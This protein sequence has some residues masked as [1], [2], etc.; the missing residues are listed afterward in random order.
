MQS[1]FWTWPWWFHIPKIALAL[2]RHSRLTQK[3]EIL[4]DWCHKYSLH[5]EEVWI[6]KGDHWP[7]FVFAALFLFVLAG[8]QE[9][10]DLTKVTGSW[11]IEVAAGE[12]YYY[13][14]MSLKEEAGSLSGTISESTGMLSNVPLADIQFDGTNLTFSFNSPT[15]PDGLERLVKAEFKLVESSLDGL[16]IV[17]S[18]D[19]SAPAKATRESE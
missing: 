16:V 15:P 2:S 4:L 19:V 11:K 17:P 1:S 3:L 18:I 9:K 13:L 8:A 7:V 6:M 10:P 12:A 14:T 5:I